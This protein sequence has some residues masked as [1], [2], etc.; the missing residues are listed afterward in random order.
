MLR[1]DCAKA[2]NMPC[3]PLGSRNAASVAARNAKNNP[4]NNPKNNAK[5]S[6]KKRAN[7]E[8]ALLKSSAGHHLMGH[9]ERKAIV[10][11]LSSDTQLLIKCQHDGDQ[12]DERLRDRSLD[13]L[14]AMPE[15]CCSPA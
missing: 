6:F 10:E 12:L 13:E 15:F 5:T 4:R 9:Q 8:A 11:S 7:A 2:R 3:D 14:M 1:R